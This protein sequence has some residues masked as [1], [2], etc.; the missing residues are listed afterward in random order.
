MVYLHPLQVQV[1]VCESVS[2]SLVESPLLD[3]G[4]VYLHEGNFGWFFP[5]AA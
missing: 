5:P 2:D 4:M 3:W 1:H